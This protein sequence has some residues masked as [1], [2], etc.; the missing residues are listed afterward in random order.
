M[1]TDYSTLA[2]LDPDAEDRS[3][4]ALLGRRLSGRFTVDEWGFDAELAV[5]LAPLAVL[6]WDASAEGADGLPE[7]GPALLLHSRRLLP[8]DRLCLSASI[9]SATGR[10]VRA[11]GTSDRAPWFPITRRLG[12]VPTDLA[13]LRSL[14]R[15][16]EVVAW[17][18]SLVVRD[19]FGV[20]VPPARVVEVAMEIGVPILPVAVRGPLL[21]RRRRIQI[22]APIATRRRSVAVTPDEV[23]A[24]V[25]RQAEALTAGC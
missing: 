21:G 16:G 3:F 19:P 13:D 7:H 2:A 6:R 11:A 22:G 20:G 8:S 23:A 18:F 9:W 15:A 17:P 5:L 12:G 25:R 1:S 10:P 4:P 14:L 24:T